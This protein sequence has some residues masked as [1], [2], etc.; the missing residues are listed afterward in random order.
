MGDT[1]DIEEKLAIRHAQW[2]LENQI[3]TVDDLRKLWRV[4]GPWLTR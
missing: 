3:H 4:Y 2:L 1:N